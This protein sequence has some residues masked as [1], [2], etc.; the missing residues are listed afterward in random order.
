M[1]DN[2]KILC[3]IKKVLDTLSQNGYFSGKLEVDFNLTSKNYKILIH[4]FERRETKKIRIT[5]EID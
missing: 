2:K 5:E 4:T 1:I 3:D